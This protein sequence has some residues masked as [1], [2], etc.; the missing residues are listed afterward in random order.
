[1]HAFKTRLEEVGLTEQW[2]K[3]EGK[4]Q[5]RS[6]AIRTRSD[7]AAFKWARAKKGDPL[8]GNLQ[9]Q[10]DAFL[11]VQFPFEEPLEEEDRKFGCLHT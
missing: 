4:F 1:M 7:P 9:Q 8:L 10:I 2:L 6:Q 3:K 5:I 11:L